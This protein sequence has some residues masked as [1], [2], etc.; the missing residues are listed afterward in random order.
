MYSGY[1][2]PPESE[3]SNRWFSKGNIDELVVGNWG[4]IKPK[5]SGKMLNINKENRFRCLAY[6]GTCADIVDGELITSGQW[7]PC[8]R[9]ELDPWK[10]SLQ[11]FSEIR[12]DKRVLM[13]VI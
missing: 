3:I 11:H 13:S 8:E 10:S 7:F 12:K 1:G 6:V 5:L 4:I 9:R 2:S